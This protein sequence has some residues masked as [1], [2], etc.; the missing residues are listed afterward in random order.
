MRGPG[1]ARELRDLE[2]A[3]KRRAGAFG[4]EGRPLD[5]DR[6]SSTSRGA[7]GS[8]DCSSLALL[9]PQPQLQPKTKTLPTCQQHRSSLGRAARASERRGEGGGGARGAGGGAGPPLPPLRGA[10]GDTPGRSRRRSAREQPESGRGASPLS[11]LR[12]AS[13]P[14]AGE[15]GKCLCV[16]VY[17]CMG[18]AVGRVRVRA[19]SRIRETGKQ[20]N[21]TQYRSPVFPSAGMKHAP[22]HQALELSIYSSQPKSSRFFPGSLCCHTRPS[23]PPNSLPLSLTVAL[24][25]NC[26][27]RSL[28]GAI[29]LLSLD[30]SRLGQCCCS[31]RRHRCCCRCRLLPRPRGLHYRVLQGGRWGRGGA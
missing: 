25:P 10:A 18:G 27:R 19:C 1:Q 16:C 15:A 14:R 5:S 6:A 21:C 20:D 11:P 23:Q 8:D 31:C 17:L 2:E 13:P 3:G 26:S 28:L 7:G 12:Q 24:N 4:G 9:S 29:F 22:T 30:V